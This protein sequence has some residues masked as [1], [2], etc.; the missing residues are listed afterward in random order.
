MFVCLCVCACLA[1]LC[2]YLVN[3]LNSC[4]FECVLCFLGACLSM[5]LYAFVFV[6]AQVLV[7]LCVGLFRGQSPL[8]V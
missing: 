6:G 8:P 4:V 1:C 5:Q 2:F 7:L 3:D